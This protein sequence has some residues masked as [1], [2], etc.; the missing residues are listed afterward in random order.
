[1]KSIL[2]KLM[3]MPHP[4]P[5]ILESNKSKSELIPIRSI[6]DC[7]RVEKGSKHCIGRG[8]IFKTVHIRTSFERK[9]AMD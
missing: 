4:N 1:M 6:K 9:G 2:I 3:K 7:A 5:V 8:F